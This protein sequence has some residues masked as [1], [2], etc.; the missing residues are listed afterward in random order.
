MRTLAFLGALL[1]GTAVITGCS[2]KPVAPKP[3][4]PPA[5]STSAVTPAANEKPAVKEDLTTPAA[6][7][8]VEVA[9]PELPATGP[10]ESLPLENQPAATTELAAAPN[11]VPTAAAAASDKPATGVT[12]DAGI[13]AYQK[14]STEVSG[15]IKANGSDTMVNMMIMWTKGFQN[16]YPGVKAEVDGKGSSAAPPAMVE[17]TANFGPMSRDWKATEVDTFE[18]KYGYK[19]VVLGTSIDML[20]VYVHKDCPLKSLTFEQVDA[21]FSSTRKGGS[22]KDI[23]KWGDLGLTG[24]WANKPISLYGRNS[25]SGTYQYF[26]EHALFGGDFKT[27]VKEQPGSSAV[28]NGVAGDIYGIGYSGIGYKTPD[29]KALALDKGKGPVEAEPANAYNATY[30][31]SRMLWLSVNYKPGSELDPLRREFVRYVFSQEGQRDVV[32]GDYL[33]VTAKIAENQ[34]KKVGLQLKTAAE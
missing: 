14:V 12:I 34:L 6:P 31:L 8:K 18:K 24:E 20:A 2:D 28:V 32:K 30:P 13:P 16:F 5:S 22:S 9:K 27:T 17:G 33:P 29:V 19:P 4:T 15:D 21:I 3:V 7:E 11:A 23:I 1:L 25:A 10:T 26:K